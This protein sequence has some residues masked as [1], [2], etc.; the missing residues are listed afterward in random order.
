MKYLVEVV[1]PGVEKLLLST[2]ANTRDEAKQNILDSY[3]NV[4]QI[5]NVEEVSM[6][7]S[8]NRSAIHCLLKCDSRKGKRK[9]YSFTGL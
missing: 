6:K 4:Q 3:L 5:L 1:V 7:F 2:R 9:S 8:K